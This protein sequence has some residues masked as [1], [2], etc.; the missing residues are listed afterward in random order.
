MVERV[1]LNCCGCNIQGEDSGPA[2]RRLRPR[3]LA[4]A[5]HR[6]GRL[7]R[8]PGIGPETVCL[9]PE[10]SGRRAEAGDSGP[11]GPETPVCLARLWHVPWVGRLRHQPKIGLKT[12]V[13]GQRL[14]CWSHL[15]RRL[16]PSWLETPTLV[17]QQRLHFV[18]DYIKPSSTSRRGC[19]FHSLSSI[20]TKLQS[21]RSSIL[22]TRTRSPFG[23]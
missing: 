8:P 21:T 6:V 7:R 10:S 4:L 16:R 22:A 3:V 9:W 14:R 1:S 17:G 15:G 20:F 2:A 5:C 19:G 11:Q 18:E 12:F 13:S 23:I